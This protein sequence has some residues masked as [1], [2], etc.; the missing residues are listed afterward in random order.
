MAKRL[1]YARGVATQAQYLHSCHSQFICAPLPPLFAT[2]V[3][4]RA[5]PRHL[6]PYPLGNGALFCA[7]RLRRDDAFGGRVGLLHGRRRCGLQRLLGAAGHRH[8][9]AADGCHRYHAPALPLAQPAHPAHPPSGC[10]AHS[11][12]RL[13]R[14]SRHCGSR[15]V[16]HSLPAHR[17][18]RLPARAV[19]FAGSPPIQHF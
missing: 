1:G 9:G 16:W 13:V 7:A 17:T 11:T 12:G 15:G 3:G 8:S 14:H 18:W 6:R 10:D 19:A 5:R 2:S 4:G